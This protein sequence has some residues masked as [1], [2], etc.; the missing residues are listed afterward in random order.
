MKKLKIFPPASLELARK[1]FVFVADF[2]TWQ[3]RG[4]RDARTFS[5]SR[6]RMC[7]RMCVK[8]LVSARPLQSLYRRSF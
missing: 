1:T 2:S 4:I 3:M 6:V 5:H 7:F 8:E